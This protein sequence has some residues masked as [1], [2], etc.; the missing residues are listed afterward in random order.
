MPTTWTQRTKPSSSWSWV[1]LWGAY[2]VN[3]LGEYI[4]TNNSEKIIVIVPWGDLSVSA[5]TWR[6]IP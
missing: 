1:R 4:L 2:L 3:T 6:I 5:W